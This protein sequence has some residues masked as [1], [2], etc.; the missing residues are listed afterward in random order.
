[1]RLSSFVKFVLLLFAFPILTFGSEKE[2][3]IDFVSTYQKI[4]KNK[5]S[6]EFKELY[7]PI[8]LKVK[9]KDFA[10]KKIVAEQDLA[11]RPAVILAYVEKDNKIFFKWASRDEKVSVEMLPWVVLEKGGQYGFLI[12]SESTDWGPESRD[13]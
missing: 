13:R 7:S 11:S 4:V 3:V 10:Q 8:L 5:D 12:I 9:A 6:K 2:K 1:M